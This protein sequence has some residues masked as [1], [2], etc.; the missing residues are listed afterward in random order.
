M[1]E[2]SGGNISGCT[3]TTV[4]RNS[5]VQFTPRQTLSRGSMSGRVLF[6]W[7]IEGY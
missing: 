6:R 1:T 7:L 3:I 5:G 2:I 4:Q